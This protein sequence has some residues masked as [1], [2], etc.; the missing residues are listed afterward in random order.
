MSDSPELWRRVHAAFE[1]H[2]RNDPSTQ[3]GLER[4]AKKCLGLTERRP[5]NQTNCTIRAEVFHPE[6]LASLV[7]YHDRTKPQREGQAIVV[8]EYQGR[9]FVIDGNNRVNKWVAEKRLEPFEAIVIA[10]NE[11]AA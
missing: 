9:R 2:S 10:A 4:I 3:A 11:G 7:R 5:F 8:L 1:G 6:Q